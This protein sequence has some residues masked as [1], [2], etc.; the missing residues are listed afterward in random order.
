MCECYSVWPYVT[1]TVWVWQCVT[2]TMWDC[3]SMRMWQCETVTVCE[4]H[5]VCV[6]MCDCNGVNVTVYGYHSVWVWQCDNVW[7]WHCVIMTVWGGKRDY[8]ESLYYYY[9]EVGDLRD[10]NMSSILCIRGLPN[11]HCPVILSVCLSGIGFSDA[12]IN[13]N[14]NLSSLARPLI[15][16]A[17]E[18]EVG[19][20]KAQVCLSYRES[21][22]PDWV[23]M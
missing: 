17:W 14:R 18:A 15:P 21:S 7:V 11:Y 5:S 6:T 12:G 13:D 19:E 16:A 8:S 10:Q 20:Q 23:G 1:T 2:V 9:K 4:C 22:K 3:D